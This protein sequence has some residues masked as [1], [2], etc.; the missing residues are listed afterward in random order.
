MSG[1]VHLF[2]VTVV[3][4]VVAGFCTGAAANWQE[5]F[6]GNAFDLPTWTFKISI[7]SPGRY[8]TFAI[9]CQAANIRSAN[10]FMRAAYLLF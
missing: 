7:P 9:S 4:L 2:K 10:Y 6:G 8:P 1:S 3:A 5:S